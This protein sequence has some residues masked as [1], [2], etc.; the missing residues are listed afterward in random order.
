MKITKELPSLIQALLKNCKN[1][2]FE[3]QHY[4]S[5]LYG[6]CVNDSYR[7]CDQTILNKPD[8]G[9]GLSR[10][11]LPF[12]TI[13]LVVSLGT[14]FFRGFWQWRIRILYRRWDFF[15]SRRNLCGCLLYG[16]GCV[17]FRFKKNMPNFPKN[18]DEFLYWPTESDTVSIKKIYCQL[19][20]K[21]FFKVLYPQ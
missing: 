21:S 8:L 20:N 15:D 14:N 1:G 12:T 19:D 5:Q 17:I 11:I 7:S 4:C 16:L 6:K 10:A 3:A 13:N 18:W 2:T 9:F